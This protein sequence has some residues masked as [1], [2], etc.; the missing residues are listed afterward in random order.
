MALCPELPDV[1]VYVEALCERVLGHTLTRAQIRGPFLLRSVTPPMDALAGRTAIDVRRAGKRIAIGFEGDLWL[2]IHLMIAG[3]LH[4]N[5][6]R[7]AA[8]RVRIR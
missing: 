3:R 4:W 7:Q 5:G 2:A 6:K 8:R 1:V